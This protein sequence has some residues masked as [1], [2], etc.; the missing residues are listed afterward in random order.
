MKDLKDLKKLDEEENV[1]TVP[2][3]PEITIDLFQETY[4]VSKEF[5]INIDHDLETPNYYRKAFD[6]LRNATCKDTITVVLNTSGGYVD[7]AVEFFN[8]LLE[9][10]ARTTAEVYTAYSAGS[11]IMFG[12]DEIKLQR[13]CSILI[14][15]LSWDSVGKADEI[16]TKSD[17]I[18]KLNRNLMT[19]V[20][21]GFLTPKEIQEIMKGKDLWLQKSEIEKKLKNW[22]PIR[23]RK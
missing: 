3:R 14:H 23:E 10:A 6:I 11:L 7:S 5:V 21:Q 17:F 8:L 18:E 15:S 2:T 19:T 12:C 16:K 20:Y 4:S 1:T 13:F 9:T 22:V